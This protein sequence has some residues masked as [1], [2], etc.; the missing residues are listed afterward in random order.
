[1]IPHQAPGNNSRRVPP[2]RFDHNT[3]ER[4]EVGLLGK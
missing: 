1:M 4:L 3:L 2:V